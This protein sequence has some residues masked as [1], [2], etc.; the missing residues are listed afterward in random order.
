MDYLNIDWD[1]EMEIQKNDV[2]HSTERFFAILNVIID[3]HMPV[4]KLT[5]KECEQKIKPWITPAII[6]KI[7]T[8]NRKKY[9]NQLLNPKL[10]LPMIERISKLEINL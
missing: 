10:R 4:R 1:S 6:A 5:V 7:N 2:N 3:K 9:I 8:K